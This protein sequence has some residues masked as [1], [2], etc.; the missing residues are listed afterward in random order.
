MLDGNRTRDLF[1][2]VFGTFSLGEVGVDGFFL[3][4]GYLITQSFLRDPALVPYLARRARRILPGYLVSYIVSLLAVGALAGGDLRTLSG[5]DGLKSL[6]RPL[7]LLQPALAGAFEGEHYPYLNGPLWTIAYEARCYLLVPLLGAAGLLRRRRALLALAAVILALLVARPDWHWPNA[8]ATVIG[9]P[10]ENLRLLSMFLCGALFR[11]YRERV[12]LNTAGAALAAI[13]A[14][15]CLFVP[16]LAE[17]ALAVLGGYLLFWFAFAVR[18]PRLSQVGTRADLSYGTY[19]YAWP[20]QALLIRYVPG[21][22]PWALFMI[23]A[24]TAMLC[25]W[26]SWVVVERRWLVR[27]DAAPAVGLR[28]AA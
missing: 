6:V 2:Q 16:A 24:P 8:V 17:P 13:L 1:T 12:P 21:L 26:L 20:V 4:S 14:A 10:R 23:A 19:L 18:L 3:L 15:P 5:L 7:L 25:G 27:S 22:Q 28:A 9:S 11:L